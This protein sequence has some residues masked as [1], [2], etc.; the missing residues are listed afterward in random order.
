MTMPNDDPFSND[1][2]VDFALSEK[3][4]RTVL[5]RYRRS[6]PILNEYRSVLEELAP[7][8]PTPITEPGR[9]SYDVREITR[10]ALV[11]LGYGPAISP[12]LLEWAR[13]YIEK[14]EFEV[15]DIAK[16]DETQTPLSVVCQHWFSMCDM[17]PTPENW[18][19]ECREERLADAREL[20][21]I[22]DG[23]MLAHVVELGIP[24][25][26]AEAIV[27]DGNSIH[28]GREDVAD[29]DARAHALLERWRGKRSV[30]DAD[31]RA[32]L[33]EV[34]QEDAQEGAEERRYTLDELTALLTAAATGA[35][36]LEEAAE[37]LQAE[38]K[39][40][41]AGEL[42]ASSVGDVDVPDVDD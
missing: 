18:V 29:W 21:S 4:Y 22:M 19:A 42:A 36:T 16:D 32:H 2:L 9:A 27:E 31:Y 12:D 25:L 35:P 14:L 30:T 41:D 6:F 11:R 20:I 13:A 34:A 10:R 15:R 5:A 33:R 8:T 40:G 17:V 24:A 1:D 3:D 7:A 26:L 37:Y 23:D 38:E 28:Q 39:D